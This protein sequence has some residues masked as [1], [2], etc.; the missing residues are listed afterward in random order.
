MLKNCWPE[1]KS[2]GRTELGLAWQLQ[3]VAVSSVVSAVR[4]EN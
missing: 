3:A 2:G 4:Q 1:L